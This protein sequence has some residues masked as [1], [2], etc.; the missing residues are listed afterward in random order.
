METAGPEE[1]PELVITVPDNCHF[2]S[3]WLQEQ[4][5]SLGMDVSMPCKT[6][7]EAM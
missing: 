5:M 1:L 6:R 7:Q 3:P 2:G 4:C